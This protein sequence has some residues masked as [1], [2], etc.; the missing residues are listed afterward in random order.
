MNIKLKIYSSFVILIATLLLFGCK[1]SE[2]FQDLRLY[3]EQLKQTEIIAQ[4]KKATPK[5]PLPVPTSYKADSLRS[6]F[7]V[8]APLT[9]KK[10]IPS[11]PLQAYPLSMLRFVGTLTEG[12]TTVA[13]IMTPDNLI[14]QVKTGDLISDNRDIVIHISPDRLDVMVKTIENEIVINQHI[15]TLQLKDEH[16]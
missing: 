6:P 1:N 11:N 15:V 4:K 16:G 7:Q 14:Y 8:T 9:G 2:P 12:E 3:I 10:A 5:R 13:F